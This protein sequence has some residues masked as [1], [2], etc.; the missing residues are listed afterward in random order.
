MITDSRIFAGMGEIKHISSAQNSLVKTLLSLKEKSR[1]RVKS[2][3]FVLE[4]R[5]ELSLALKAGYQIDRLILCPDILGETARAEWDDIKVHERIT[6]SPEVYRKIAHRGGTEGVMAIAEARDHSID[7][8]RVTR[9][10]PLI[11]IAESPEKPGNIGALLR[12]ADAAG[13]DAVIIANPRYDLYNPNLIRSSVGCL[14]TTNIATGSTGEILGYLKSIG[15]DLYCAALSGAVN[16]TEADMKGSCAIAVG[17][18]AT[19]L[20]GEWLE[21][22]RANILIPMSGQID[23]LN[24]SVSAAILIFEAK[25]QRGYRPSL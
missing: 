20:S 25:R 11:L 24:V 9:K 23:S 1:E 15:C 12:T 8:L 3:L 10:D 22:S 21:N 18:E 4:G 17:T 6:V 13:L 2:G 19:G 7:Q 16:Y 5:R 14:F